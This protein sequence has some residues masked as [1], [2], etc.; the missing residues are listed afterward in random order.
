[1]GIYIHRNLGKIGKTRINYSKRIDGKGGCLSDCLKICI[2]P[3]MLV[4]GLYA[5]I[6]KGIAALIRAI[7]KKPKPETAPNIAEDYQNIPKDTEGEE[8]EMNAEKKKEG[9]STKKKVIVGIVAF[10]LIGGSISYAMNPKE[11]SKPEETSAVTEAAIEPERGMPVFAESE[12]DVQTEPNTEAVT[13][14]ETEKAT[15]APKQKETEET[16]KQEPKTEVKQEQKQ[17]EEKKSTERAVNAT[18]YALYNVKARTTPSDSAE[19]IGTVYAGTAVTVV[20]VDDATGWAKVKNGTGYIYILWQYLSKDK[21][22]ESETEAKREVHDPEYKLTLSVTSPVDNNSMAT[23]TA[24]GK[25]NTV[26][27]IS[28]YYSTKESGAQGL[29]NKTSDANGNVSWTWKVGGNTNPG[30]HKITVYAKNDKNDTATIE[31]ETVK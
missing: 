11:N 19:S 17:K 6:F 18:M 5:L 20:S 27:H 30:K 13:E 26:Y 29:E 22:P 9:W 1:M 2:F 7:T 4:I 3:I 15:E 25:P 28:V 10:T 16:K 24:K 31:F 8:K 12:T 14:K 21:P 23:L